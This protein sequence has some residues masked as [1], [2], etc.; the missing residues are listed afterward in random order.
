M[1][2]FPAFWHTMK[3]V[4]LNV[5][6]AVCAPNRSCLWIKSSILISTRKLMPN[7]TQKAP[8]RLKH[9]SLIR[10]KLIGHTIYE[11]WTGIKKMREEKYKIS[12]SSL[13]ASTLHSIGMCKYLGSIASL[14]SL[15]MKF[16]F[17]LLFYYSIIMCG[18]G[19]FS[20]HFSVSSDECIV[21]ECW[22]ASDH[23]K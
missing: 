7:G 4:P 2:Q 14:S 10:L 9:H 23:S 8:I 22:N 6:L 13:L 19:V 16:F 11:Q 5:R 21:I 1:R 3:T 12:L 15:Y 17:L 18:C 20:A